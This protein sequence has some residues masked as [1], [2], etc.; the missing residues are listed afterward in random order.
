MCVFNILIAPH[1]KQCNNSVSELTQLLQLFSN[2]FHAESWCNIWVYLSLLAYSMICHLQWKEEYVLGTLE[3]AISSYDGHIVNV[4][5][6]LLC[7]QEKCH[8]VITVVFHNIITY[9]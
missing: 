8:N 9:F 5:L 4:W 2:T 7:L 3:W 6:Y 1:I